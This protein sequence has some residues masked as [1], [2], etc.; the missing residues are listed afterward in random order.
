MINMKNIFIITLLLSVFGMSQDMAKSKEVNIEKTLQTIVS[1]YSKET[2]NT[3]ILLLV[4]KGDKTYKASAG[5]A[6]RES[7]ETIKSSDLFEI[8]SSSKVFTGVAIFQLI[9]SGKLSLDTK[10]KTFYPKGDIT[11]LANY[12]GTNYWDDVTVG[13]LLQH[14]SGFIDYLNVYGDDSKAL[15]ILGGKD[16][17]FTFSQ[18]ID[19]SISFGDANFKA[20]EE[21]KYCNTGYVILGDIISKVSGLDWHEYIQ[22][23]ILD[24]VGMKQTY[25][26]SLISPKLRSSMPKGYMQSK[27]T[28]MPPSLASSAGEIISTLD[29]LALFMKAWSKGELY[30]DSKTLTLQMEKGFHQ[31]SKKIENLFY[32]YA[33]MKLEGFYGHGGQTFGFQSYITVNPKTDTIYIVGTNDSTIASMNLFM[34]IANIQFKYITKGK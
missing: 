18:L 12:K 21:F 28:F 1:F 19:M 31:E 11:K 6:N 8:G 24:K 15:K 29:D 17:H 33:I 14:T 30:K 5:L 13:M 32:G 3:A 2:N 20:G 34:Q 27:E 22:K 23:N 4:S 7:G 16:K 9:E 25:F 10:I 26:G